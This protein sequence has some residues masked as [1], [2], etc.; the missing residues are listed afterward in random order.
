MKPLTYALLCVAALIGSRLAHL[1]LPKGGLEVRTLPKVSDAEFAVM[2]EEVLSLVTED[3]ALELEHLGE[4]YFML[5]HQ[6]PTALAGRQLCNQ[7]AG[8][9]LL[10]GCEQAS[11]SVEPQAS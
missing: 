11:D 9:T 3:A 7:H 5:S 2:R 10:S 1:Y 8:H 6:R 4:R